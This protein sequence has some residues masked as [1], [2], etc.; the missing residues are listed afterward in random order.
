MITY[1]NYHKA[2]YGV[3]R[4]IDSLPSGIERDYTSPIGSEYWRGKD[5]GGEFLIRRSDH[6]SGFVRPEDDDILVRAQLRREWFTRIRSC[7][8][9]LFFPNITEWWYARL[10]KVHIGK[11]YLSELSETFTGI[12]LEDFVVMGSSSDKV[13][14]L[15]S[16][17]SL[18]KGQDGKAISRGLARYHTHHTGTMDGRRSMLGEHRAIRE[19]VGD[20]MDE[21]ISLRGFVELFDSIAGSGSMS[22]DG[23]YEVRIDSFVV[24]LSA[25]YVID[26][27][28]PTGDELLNGLWLTVRDE[29]GFSGSRVVSYDPVADD[30]YVTKAMAEDYF[31]MFKTFLA[32]LQSEGSA[33]SA[34][35]ESFEEIDGMEFVRF[36]AQDGQLI[37]Y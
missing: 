32:L 27:E 30:G 25:Q 11:I 3:W 6:W 26:D 24:T 1:D 21:P 34:I 13:K 23:Y 35:Y 14:V 5:E 20:S 19:K 29:G 12:P 37:P 18:A 22:M 10:Q 2:T 33:I 15:E 17:S 4:S 7:F 36:K 9:W 31:A 16:A 28:E 8:W